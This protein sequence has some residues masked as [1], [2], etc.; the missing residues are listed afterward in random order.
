MSAPPERHVRSIDG[1]CERSARAAIA[2]LKRAASAGLFRSAS[3]VALL[4]RDN[5]AFL[6]NRDDF[7]RFRAELTAPR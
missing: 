5:L 7:K 4:D 3:N 1:C 6:R 2:L